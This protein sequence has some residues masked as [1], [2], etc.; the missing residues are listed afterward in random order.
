MDSLLVFVLLHSVRDMSRITTFWRGPYAWLLSCLL[1]SFF[2]LAYPLYVIRPFRYQG[3]RELNAALAI[4]RIRATVQI[5]LA[6]AAAILGVWCWRRSRR[7]APRVLA[8]L[9]ALATL[10]CGM[11]SRINIYELMFNPLGDPVFTSAAKTKLEG[12]EQVIAVKLASA[13]RAYPIRVIS[14]HHMVNDVVAG[15]PIVATY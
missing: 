7:T 14:Y 13:A 3:P 11:V 9:A 8:A 15:V 10:G 5:A 1:A 12:T 6:S 2:I 4:L